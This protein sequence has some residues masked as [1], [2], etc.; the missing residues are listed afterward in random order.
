[1]EGLII[2]IQLLNP[3]LCRRFRMTIFVGCPRKHT[4]YRVDICG[5]RFDLRSFLL[6]AVSSCCQR[7]GRACMFQA[8]I[9][10]AEEVM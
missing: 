3:V 5:N 1:M 2:A 8:V 4:T 6:L 9:E 7:A 10:F